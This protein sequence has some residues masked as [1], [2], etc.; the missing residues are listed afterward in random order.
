[1]TWQDN[2]AA[3]QD[4]TGWPS[5]SHGWDSTDDCCYAP[6]GIGGPGWTPLICNYVTGDGTAASGAREEN[7]GTYATSAECAIAVRSQHPTANGATYST[8]GTHACY[9]EY[10]MSMANSNSA[11]Q[12]CLFGG[13]PPPPGWHAPPPAPCAQQQCAGGNSG[14]GGNL[15]EGDGD[16]D[17]DS[18]CAPGLHCGTDNCGAFRSTA[19]WPSDGPGWDLTDECALTNPT[20]ATQA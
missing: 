15:C 3:F 11:W 12:T 4:G 16:C 18:D 6:G 2:C 5:S 9:A 7:I 20:R 8:T 14:C 13:W 1:M 10:G 17:R 19:G